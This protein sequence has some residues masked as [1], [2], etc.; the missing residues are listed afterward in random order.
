MIDLNLIGWNGWRIT[1]PIF[2]REGALVFFKQAR[3]PDKSNSPKMIAWPKGHLEL[4]GWENLT[5]DSSQ[6][7][8]CEGEFDRLVLEANG[9]KTVTSTGGARSFK[10]EW[11]TEFESIPDVYI[12]FDNDEAGRKGAL[13]VGR[14]IPRARIVEL[15]TEV[16]ENGDVTDFFVRL[17]RNREDFLKLLQEA[18]PA[19]PEA[20]A[21]RF[22]R[23]ARNDDSRERVERV[24]SVSPIAQIVGQYVQLR[25]SG[26]NLVGLCPFHEDRIP[27][28]TVYPATGTFHCYGCGKHGDVIS[29][30]GLVEHLNFGQVLDAL[31]RFNYQHE[32][33]S[34]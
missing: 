27:S 20:E 29:F 18:K 33:E 28:F 30:L 24:K 25:P 23:K 15:P 13:R 19:P 4:Y 7:I 12:C 11:T 6:I 31:D 8:I 21:P 3:D 1:I 32:S 9:F 26:N 14:L 5:S 10:K 16:G 17:G 34:Q 2:N 22:V